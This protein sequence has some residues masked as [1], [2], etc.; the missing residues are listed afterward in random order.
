VKDTAGPGRSNPV[1]GFLSRLESAQP[2]DKVGQPVNDVAHRLLR[3]GRIRD[4]LSGTAIGHPAHPALVSAPIGCWTG[5]M[6]ADMFGER[7]AGRLLTA[8]GVL[9][10][11]PVAATGLSDWADTTGAEQ[12]V[13]VVHM[14]L[15]LTAT[16]LYAASWWARARQRDGVGVALGAGGAVVA[17]TAGW[18]GGHLAYGLGVGVDTNSFE[19][20]PTEWTAVD[21]DRSGQRTLTGGVVSGV[22]V[23][24]A[25][26]DDAGRP[27]VLANRCSHRGGPL[28]EGE[29]VGGCIRCPWHDSEFDLT[30]GAV[31]R[32]PAVVP[33][34]VYEVRGSGEDLLEVRRDEPRSLRLNSVRP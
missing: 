7:R 25:R 24:V 12:R 18:L 16:A 27:H 26:P 23:V 30:T 29:L 9:S 6:V 21:E 14:A 33:Q 19:G 10:A 3:P 13:G 8:A 20:G 2:L 34:A 32:G 28:A 17:T 11:V 4:L 22:G 5:A 15:N 31:R 1:S